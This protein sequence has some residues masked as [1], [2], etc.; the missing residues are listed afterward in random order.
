MP[1]LFSVFA[2]S[3]PVPGFND[4]TLQ[5]AFT[6]LRQVSLG[7]SH[8]WGRNIKGQ[9][10]FSFVFQNCIIS[11]VVAAVNSTKMTSWLLQWFSLNLP[12]LSPKKHKDFSA[13]WRLTIKHDNVN[14]LTS[15]M[16]DLFIGWDWTTFFADYGKP[17]S[18]YLRV[19]PSNAIILLEKWVRFVR[20]H[21]SLNVQFSL[22]WKLYACTYLQLFKSAICFCRLTNA[23]K[24]KNNLLTTFKRNERDKKKLNDTILRQLRQLMNGDMQ[25]TVW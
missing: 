5:L 17:G 11:C 22:L 18:K 20:L 6:D 15:Q 4:G 8:F 2:N 16:L 9:N 10:W 7:W 21:L 3:E 13:V 23:D 14:F 12:D 1:A 19:N 25:N 24:K